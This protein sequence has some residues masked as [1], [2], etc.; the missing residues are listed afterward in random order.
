MS[1]KREVRRPNGAS[2]IRCAIYTRKSSEEGL[3]QEF[4]S[5]DAQR[6]ACEAYIKSQKSAGWVALPEMYDDGGISGGTMERPAL[7]RLLDD[8]AAGRIDTVVV[9]KVDRLTR[10]L[11]DFAKIVDAFDAKGVSFVSVTQQFNTTTSMGRLTLNMLLSFAQFEREVTGER[12][13]DKIAASKQ[14][15]MWMGGNPPLGYDVADRKLVV[16]AT[17]AETVRHIFRRYVALKSVLA[18]QHELA[19]DGIVSKARLDHHGRQ[20]GSKPIARGAVYLMLQNRIY[21]GE[22]VHKDKAYPGLHEPIIEQALWDEVQA[23]LAENRVE[24]TTRSKAVDPSLLAGLVYDDSGECMSPTHASKNGT[25]YR[26]Y[27]SQSLIKRGR[28]QASEAACRV[29]AADLE[30]IVEDRICA[31][32]KHEDAIFNAAGATTVAS[33]KTMIENSANLALRWPALPASAKRGILHALVERVDIRPE[34]IEISIRLT[35]LPDIAKPDL[36]MR[37]LPRKPEGAIE[38]LSVPAR[39]RRTGMETKLLIQGT[40]GAEPPRRSRPVAMCGRHPRCKRNLA[41]LLA[42][43]CKSCVRPV[44]AAHDRWP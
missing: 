40:L 36:N 43:G 25:R 4:N 27:V 42:V 14:K 31:L 29:P 33:R 37:R 44:V 2:V 13:R 24:R 38:V 23:A 12:I 21:R 10:S 18:L 5:L 6:E 26:Y 34:T 20:R 11:S 30:H 7:Q 17:E 35:A 9:Y 3:E 15:G 32:L 8:I 16:N 1:R 28:P 41:S 39:L 19:G 22:I